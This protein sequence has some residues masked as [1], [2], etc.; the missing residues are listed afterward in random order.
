M[1]THEEM[2]KCEGPRSRAL[3]ECMDD[4]STR[5]CSVQADDARSFYERAW[6]TAAQTQD[7]A[8]MDEHLCVVE[9]AGQTC[10]LS[11]EELVGSIGIPF[12]YIRIAIRT[13]GHS[14]FL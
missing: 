2:R 1:K 11:I 13:K 3:P 6:C 12:Y 10:G 9:R 4:A 14:I 5:S 8:A 7:K